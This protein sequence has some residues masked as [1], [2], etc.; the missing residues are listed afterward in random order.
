MTPTT[1]FRRAE[2]VVSTTRSGQTVLLDVTGETYHTLNEVGT[3]VWEMLD[4]GTT[5]EAAVQTILDEYVLPIG[6]S[7]GD[8]ARD[9]ERLFIQ[10]QSA[11]LV[12]RDSTPA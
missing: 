3:R 7:P 10:L 11:R 1:P 8:V 12:G 6:V 4:S 2:H 5:L 9:L